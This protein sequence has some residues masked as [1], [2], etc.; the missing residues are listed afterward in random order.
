MWNAMNFIQTT[1]GWVYN[2]Q[3]YN[4]WR[5]IFTGNQQGAVEEVN[6]ARN[7]ARGFREGIEVA[8]VV[9]VPAANGVVERRGKHLVLHRTLGRAA[10]AAVLLVSTD[11]FRVERK[12]RFERMEFRFKRMELRFERIE[13]RFQRMN[14]D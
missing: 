9:Q 11:R 13:F 7:F 14:L 4:G 10:V 1:N 2:G 8:V 5:F 12:S 6:H 3:W